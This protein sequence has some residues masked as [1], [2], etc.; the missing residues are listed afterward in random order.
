MEDPMKDKE[1]ILEDY[2]ILRGFEDVFEE[3]PRLPPKRDIDF[4]IDLMIGAAPVSKTP[5]RMSIPELKE[6]QV[7]LEELLKKGCICPSVSPW[8]TLVIFV[9]K[10]DGMLRFCIE[11][12]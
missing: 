12:R 10:K 3:L 9:K 1:A 4:S 7:Q 5:Y 2:S 8:G 11:F 6:L